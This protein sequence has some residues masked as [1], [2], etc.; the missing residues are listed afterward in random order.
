[1]HF[2]ITKGIP[3]IYS[4]IETNLDTSSDYS[5]IIVTLSNHVIWKEPPQLSNRNTNWIQFKD[6][7]NDNISLNIR[8]K[9][10]QDLEEAVNYITTLIQT[11]AWISTPERKTITQEAH[12]VPLHIRELVY[13][14]R[15]ARR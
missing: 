6:Y 8:L 1:V 4:S 9:E 12:N 3:D 15:Q 2:A 11:A 13:K 14:N 10:H 5:P 7:I